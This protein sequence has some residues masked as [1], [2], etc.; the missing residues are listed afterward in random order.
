[1]SYLEHPQHAAWRE[2]Y[3][4][5]AHGSW[6]LAIDPA[7]WAAHMPKSGSNLLRVEY[8]DRTDNKRY[9]AA[10]YAA[11]DDFNEV[12]FPGF[13][14]D[15]NHLNATGVKALKEY[16]Y[17]DHHCPCHRKQDARAAGADTD[18]E[19]EGDRF[20]IL[21]IWWPGL[22]NLILYSEV[23]T[24][25]ELEQHLNGTYGGDGLLR[26]IFP[27]TEVSD[28]EIDRMVDTDKPVKIMD[29]T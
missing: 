23:L 2:H 1:M 26:Q 28:E 25:E 15:W 7:W 10:M 16:F 3:F 12:W 11:W 21:R 14:E 8:L 4:A 9:E 5:D 17:N 24:S 19:C 29:K 27:P 13:D 18:E 6:H 22:P 20:P